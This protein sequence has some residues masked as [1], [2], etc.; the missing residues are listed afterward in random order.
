MMTL[1]ITV[2]YVSMWRYKKKITYGCIVP[3][4]LRRIFFTSAQGF[5]HVKII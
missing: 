1:L 2:I 3:I 4:T 5:F